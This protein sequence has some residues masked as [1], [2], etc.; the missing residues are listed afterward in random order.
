MK[1]VQCESCQKI[2][3]VGDADLTQQKVC[4][5][6]NTTIHEVFT[7]SEYD[8][9]DKLL[10][11]A[12]SKRGKEVLHNPGQLLGYMMDTA[13]ALRREI[14]IF[15][16]AMNKPYVDHVVNAFEQ[17]SAK[18]KETLK[19]LHFQMMNE[20][21]LSEEWAD[22]IC[23]RVLDAI[24]HMEKTGTSV[25]VNVK[26][27]DCISTDQVKKTETFITRQEAE[28]IYGK[29]EKELEDI[30]NELVSVF[31]EL[32]FDPKINFA[33]NRIYERA[34][35]LREISDRTLDEK[36]VMERAMD[37]V[38]VSVSMQANMIGIRVS[39]LGSIF[40]S[41]KKDMRKLRLYILY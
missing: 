1:K 38:L 4:P 24:H 18:A 27:D 25:L 21:G 30:Q 10:F 22:M 41:L 14:R 7:F 6:C 39:K 11:G 9:L 17:E 5:F 35:E 23:G 12:V 16:K 33:K 20:E 37:E 32:M 31:K 34:K 2:W 13:P 36:A 40:N 28:E 15:S 29:V 3:Y 19:K 26:V 8:T